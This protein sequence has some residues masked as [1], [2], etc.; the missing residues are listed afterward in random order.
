LVLFCEEGGFIMMAVEV[1]RA[2][3]SRF[4]SNGLE[5]AV[6][7]DSQ[8]YGQS[9]PSD[10]DIIIDQRSLNRAR[11]TIVE[12][13]TELGLALVQCIQHEANSWY[14]AIAW[15]DHGDQV[16]YLH[17]DIGGDYYRDGRLLLRSRDVLEGCVPAL[18]THGRALGFKVPAP[19]QA[20]IYYLLKRI[21]KGAL[22]QPQ[23]EYLSDQWSRDPEGAQVQLA[24]WW[25]DAHV[26]LL[27]TAAASDQWP[28]VVDALPDLG[29]EIRGHSPVVP[30]TY[31]RESGRV[32]RRIAH[33]TGFW[34]TFLG[35]D[36]CGKSTVISHV[37]DELAPAFRRTRRYHLR[38]HLE[39][40]D[41]R[42]GVVVTDP[43]A[44]PPRGKVMSTLKLGYWWIDYSLGYLVSVFPALVRSTL[45]LF[46]RYYDDIEVDP[47]RYRYGGSTWLARQL[48][49][50]IP[51]PNLIVVLDLPATVAHE[52]K[53]EVPLAEIERQRTLY[54]DIARRHEKGHLVD[55][56]RPLEDVVRDV[57]QLILGAL[58]RRIT[59]T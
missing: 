29:M 35:P 39:V 58:E 21:E 31:V 34:I 23:G 13:C 42:D 37:R 18:D 20:F 17:P 6:V 14:Y 12:F 59:T 19:A 24:R 41:A 27:A 25:S 43:H 45:V 11:T 52:R 56:S 30:R 10:L 7:G 26:D 55:A 48:G 46:D 9:I 2:L 50:V 44:Q 8:G 4:E 32:V 57:T 53:K 40:R 33:P 28:A 49:R 1:A 22:A 5:Y 38:P 16:S 15:R 47:R 3:F 51:R 54:R 36:G